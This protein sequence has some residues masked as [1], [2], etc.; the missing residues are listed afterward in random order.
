M[1][2]KLL[3]LRIYNTLTFLRYVTNMLQSGGEKVVI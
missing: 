2:S 3:M 1:K